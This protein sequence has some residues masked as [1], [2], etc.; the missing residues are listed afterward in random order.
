MLMYSCRYANSD[1][2]KNRY[3]NMVFD[4]RPQE[5]TLKQEGL[6]NSNKVRMVYYSLVMTLMI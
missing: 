2:C 3:N 1:C 6:N 5:K 4:Y